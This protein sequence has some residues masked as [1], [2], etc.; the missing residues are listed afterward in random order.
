[1]GPGIGNQVFP[2]E[3]PHIASGSLPGRP[4]ALS[5]VNA[6]MGDVM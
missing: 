1:M 3:E 4:E 2:G 6:L 5:P